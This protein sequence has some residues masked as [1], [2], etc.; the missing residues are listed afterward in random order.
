MPAIA[1]IDPK[2]VFTPEEWA[3]LTQKSQWMGP[4][5]VAHAWGLVAVA[6]A[7]VAIW[8]N[9]VTWL[10]AVMIVGARQLGLAILMHEAAHGA[11]HPNQ[12][13]NDFMG[14]WLCASPVGGSLPGYRPYHLTHHRFAQQV[15]DP[16]LSLSAPFPITL[17]SFWR[18][19]ARD[20]SGQ[21]FFKQRIAPVIAALEGR[22]G[23]AHPEQRLLTSTRSLAPF[24]GTNAVLL[25]IFAL[26]GVWHLYFLVWIVGMATWFPFVTRV[27]NIGEH[28]CVENDHD[29]WRQARTTLANPLERLLI[30]PY[31]VH[32]HLEHHLFMYLSCWKLEAAHKMLV[33]KGFVEKMPV[34]RGYRDVLKI[35]TSRAAP[36]AA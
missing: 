27:R 35:A 6:V 9:P 13:V 8:P 25:A 12:K 17:E 31:W 5:L 21:T 1:R 7:L 29:P 15:E 32:Y 18:K 19:A 24:L 4:L 22:D 33:A 23:E 3:S 26:A 11:L 28:A 14:Q 36:A 16:D 10:I 34:T 2:T 30:A 20:L